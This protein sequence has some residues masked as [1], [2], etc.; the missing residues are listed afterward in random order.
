MRSA[1]LSVASPA[2]IPRN[3][4]RPGAPLPMMLPYPEVLSRRGGLEQC[5]SSA[6]S[7]LEQR[8]KYW[9]NIQVAY[10]NYILCGQPKGSQKSEWM[11]RP[12]CAQQT[13]AARGW[14][15]DARLFLKSSGGEL[16]TL[17]R[18][19]AR[20][21]HLVGNVATPMD[22]NVNR[23]VTSVN[24]DAYAQTVIPEK[25]SLPGRVAGLRPAEVLCPERARV[26]RDLNRIVLP[27]DK[28]PPLCIRSCHKIS[29]DGR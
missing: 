12:L 1:A 6:T 19:R 22:A 2:S 24:A 27:D 4:P 21:L 13:S 7:C 8:S 29:V 28:V 17:G 16:P 25:V 5:V 15:D 20:L 26:V 14:L 18:G 9:V 11:S 3:I 10:A 23:M